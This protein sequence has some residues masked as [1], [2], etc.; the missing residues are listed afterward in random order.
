[1]SAFLGSTGKADS[2]YST[3]NKSFGSRGLV[4]FSKYLEHICSALVLGAASGETER[5]QSFKSGG[6]DFLCRRKLH[7]SMS[8]A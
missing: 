8:S 3:E 7:S 2:L 6:R 4:S 1:M 5:G